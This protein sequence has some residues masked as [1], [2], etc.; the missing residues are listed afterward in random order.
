MAG[1]DVIRTPS[2]ISMSADPQTL[3]ASLSKGKDW[4]QQRTTRVIPL[5]VS[6]LLGTYTFVNYGTLS[7]IDRRRHEFDEIFLTSIWF[8]SASERDV[9]GAF[10]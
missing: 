1:K 3:S 6:S 4:H 8:Q 2:C 10:I 7:K 5:Q 9:S